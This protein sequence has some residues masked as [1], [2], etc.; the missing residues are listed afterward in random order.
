MKKIHSL[1]LVALMSFISFS[2]KAAIVQLASGDVNAAVKTAVS[3]DIIELT[4]SGGAYTWINGANDGTINVANLTI[5]AAAGLAARPVITYTNSWGY[6]WFINIATGTNFTMSGIEVNGSNASTFFIDNTAGVGANVTANFD[7]CKFYGIKNGSDFLK[8]YVQPTTF[9][10][11]LTNSSFVLSNNSI[12]Y[13]T[14]G[15]GYYVTTLNASNCLFKGTSRSIGTIAYLGWGPTWQPSNAT[16]DHCTFTGNTG[17]ADLTNITTK[18]GVATITNCLFIGSGAASSI[19]STSLDNG[20]TGIYPAGNLTY[21]TTSGANTLTAN[22]ILDGSGYATGS[23]YIGT[24]TDGKNIGY[25]DPNASTGPTPT[26]ISSG[27]LTSFGYTVGSGPSSSQSFTASG[28]NLTA[29]IVITAPANYEVST[30]AGSGYSTSVTLT[31]AGGTV[32]TTTIYARLVA[33]LSANT[34]TGNIAV[35]SV[36]ATAANVA[37]TGTVV[38]VPG[39]TQLASGNVSAAVAAATSGDIIELTTDGGAYTWN[40]AINVLISQANLTIRAASGLTNRPVITVVNNF[41]NVACFNFSAATNFSL[42]GVEIKNSATDAYNNFITTSTTDNVTLN[43]DNCKF[44]NIKSGKD[45]FHPGTQPSVFALNITNSIF[46]INN[47]SL[48]YL[49]SNNGNHVTD[50]NINNTLFTGTSMSVG[51]IAFLGWGNSFQP[52]SI[53][54]NH[55]T[56]AGNTGQADLV[57]ATTKTSVSPA[58]ITNSLFVGSGAA[59]SIGTVS[60]DNL[61]TGIFPAANISFFATAGSNT[62][63]TDPVIGSNGVATGFSNNGSDGKT[64]GYYGV[65]GLGTSVSKL[66]TDNNLMVYQNNSCFKVLGAQENAVYSI[67][68][69]TGSQL[70]TGIIKNKSFDLNLSKGIYLFKSNNQVTKFSV[71]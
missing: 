15:T 54:L 70:A 66:S 68:S 30:S 46:S 25:Y 11:N 58:T 29:N 10:L 16:I 3:G 38:P 51:T 44:S 12:F 63:T 18:T 53:V 23:A 32:A 59:S 21:F 19:G 27:T 55:C 14:N 42:Q 71:K 36:G 67:I 57:N 61:T 7:N 65:S 34:Y 28:S 60:L 6:N 1:F 41:A 8:M 50:L 56:F 2:V 47:N 69:L 45:I 20:S 43:I 48:L 33:G 35:A 64:I 9:I 49:D 52:S 4:T 17:Q 37:V 13:D 62:L 5:R 31:Q 40:A 26:I 24:G 39:I 22:P